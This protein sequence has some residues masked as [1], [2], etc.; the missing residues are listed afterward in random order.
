MGFQY[1]TQEEIEPPERRMEESWEMGGVPISLCRL[2]F[3]I[4]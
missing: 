4:T 2:S 3:R 1:K